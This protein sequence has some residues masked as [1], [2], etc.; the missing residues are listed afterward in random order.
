M[1]KA[2]AQVAELIGAD[3][4]EIIFTSARNAPQRAPCTFAR[5]E[6]GARLNR[7]RHHA[8]ASHL[9]SCPRPPP[10]RRARRRA[11]TWR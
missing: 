6:N 1:E 9:M 10:P 4:K 3:P 5:F 8:A 2:R 7:R 11:T